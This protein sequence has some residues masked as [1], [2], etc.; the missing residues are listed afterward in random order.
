MS[1]EERGGNFQSKKFHCFF[2]KL[3]VIYEQARKLD[4]CDTYLRNLKTKAVWTFSKKHPFGGDIH[5]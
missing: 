3:T 5:P 2:G 1:E 4:R